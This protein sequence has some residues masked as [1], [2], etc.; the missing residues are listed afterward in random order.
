MRDPPSFFPMRCRRALQA[1]VGHATEVAQSLARVERSA[2]GSSER[3]PH[4]WMGPIV[5]ANASAFLEGLGSGSNVLGA[6]GE[7]VEVGLCSSLLP[8]VLET[9]E[10]VVGSPGGTD[11]PLGLP[12]LGVVPKDAF[13][14]VVSAGGVGGGS[15]GGAVA[16]G[17]LVHLCACFAPFSSEVSI[18]LR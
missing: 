15:E 6:K 12:K 10:D 3:E 4:S 17:R 7:N 14:T 13:D 1:W 5:I 8:K 2:R 11:C 16:L 18:H 9:L